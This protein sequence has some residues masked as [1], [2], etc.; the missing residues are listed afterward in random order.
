MTIRPRP[1]RRGPILFVLCV[2]LVVAILLHRSRLLLGLLFED[3]AHNAIYPAAIIA[4]DAPKGSPLIPK[5]IHQ[6]YKNTSLPLMW[7]EQQKQL[8]DLHPDYE[9]MVSG[10]GAHLHSGSLTQTIVLDRR[11]GASI[12]CRRISLVPAHL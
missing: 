9:Y 11:L 7:A 3:G 10:S 6:T 1:S 2:V 5:I 12:H 4:Q 8:L